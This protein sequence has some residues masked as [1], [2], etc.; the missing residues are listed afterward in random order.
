MLEPRTRDGLVNQALARKEGT[1]WYKDGGNITVTRVPGQEGA[2]GNVAEK[3]KVKES[4]KANLRKLLKYKAWDRWRWTLVEDGEFTVKEI[5]RLIEEKILLSDNGDRETLWN[6][7]VPKKVNIFIWRA[8]RGRLPVRVELDRRD[9][10]DKFTTRRSCLFLQK[11]NT[12]KFLSKTYIRQ[13]AIFLKKNFIASGGFG[14]VYQG[15][16]DKLGMVAIKRLDRK[17]GQGDREFMMEIAL[18]STY[19]HENIVSLVGFSNKDGEKI[20]VYKHERNGSL[21]KYLHRKDLTWIQRLQICI[22]AARGLKYLHHD[23]GLQHRIIHRDIKSSNIL[24]D[25]NWRAK[26]SDFGLSKVGPANVQHTFLISQACG[27]I[28]HIDPEYLDTG[29]LTKESDVYSFGVVLF[30]VLCGRPA[31]VMDERQYLNTLAQIHYEEETTLVELIPSDFLEQINTASLSTFSTIAYK[32]LRK[33]RQ[34]R[35]TMTLVVEELEEALNYQLASS[36]SG[37]IVHNFVE[38]R[39]KNNLTHSDMRIQ[40]ARLPTLSFSYSTLASSKSWSNNVFL[41]FGGEDDICLSFVDHLR[42]ALVQNGIDTYMRGISVSPSFMKAI[43]ESQIAL[44]VFSK[45]CISCRFLDEFA[46]IMKCME[47]RGQVVKAIFYGVDSVLQMKVGSW[48]NAMMNASNLSGWVPKYFANGNDSK[49]INQIV[50]TVSLGLLPLMS[51]SPKSLIGIETRMLNLKSLLEIGAGDVRMIG[52]WGIGGGGKSTL[53]FSIYMEI[54]HEFDRWCFIANIRE[55]ASSHGL[56][57]LQQKI[58]FSPKSLTGIETRMLNLKSLLEIGAGDVRMIGIW[59]I[60]GGGKSTLA[61]SIYMEICHE[62]DRWC[63][64]ANIREEASSHG[65]NE[66]Q[67]KI[68]MDVLKPKQVVVSSIEEGKSMIKSRLYG[69][70]VL[71]VLDD[72]D[73]IDQ[74]KAL[75]GSKDWFGKGSRIIITTRNEDLLN[76]HEV[77]GTYTGD[78]DGLEHEEKELFLE[79]TCLIDANLGL[80]ALMILDACGFDSVKRVNVLIQKALIT[81]SNGV[82]IMHDLVKEMGLY[83]VRREH[84]NIPEHSRVWQKEDFLSICYTDATEVNTK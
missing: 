48:R 80:S 83:I 37:P 64:I 6:K 76:A 43:Q 84:P 70:S 18:L 67:Q 57:E 50:D 26:I 65:L 72:V 51:S 69:I 11:W 25:E 16:S 79:I 61:F 38:H 5:S 36:G 77:N 62:F 42:S 15:Q 4:M 54:C 52:I 8:L 33:H 73:H 49:C 19:K 31:H 41:S 46:C 35:P 66:L 2:K 10:H 82:I 21:D 27:T 14:K 30:E 29:V 44:I 81:I 60:G 45:N 22:D 59:G 53:A 74:L 7:L 58:L 12:C 40:Q 13:L 1:P 78:Y 3:K 55:E 9:L 68:P 39:E 17:H 28:G 47:E 24:L 71:M 34:D 32:C 56:N 23:V 75:A 20:L 63:F